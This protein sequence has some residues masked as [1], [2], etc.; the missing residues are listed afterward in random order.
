MCQTI[1]AEATAAERA[2]VELVR[3]CLSQQDCAAYTACIT[4]VFEKRFAK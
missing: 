4:P 2:D 3:G 1:V